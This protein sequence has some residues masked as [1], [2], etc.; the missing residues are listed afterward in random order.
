M[1]WKRA[2]RRKKSFAEVS[3]VEEEEEEK[4]NREEHGRAAKTKKTGAGRGF[5]H[6][7]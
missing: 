4:K 2:D 3:L 1:R 5:Q 6:S 7:S